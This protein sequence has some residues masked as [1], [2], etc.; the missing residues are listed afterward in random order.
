MPISADI[1]Y[2][3][4]LEN[5]DQSSRGHAATRT[6]TEARQIDRAEAIVAISGLGVPRSAVAKLTGMTRGRI[7]QILE[8]AGKAGATGDAW[9]D[10]ELRRLVAER[11]AARPVPS[12]GIGLRRESVSGPHLGSGAGLM[13]RLTGDLEDDRG[14]LIEIARNL[15]VELESGKLDQL[16]ALTEDEREV[17]EGNLLGGEGQQV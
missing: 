2:A 3:Q 15:A 9:K 10:P 7:Q 12:A 1:D 17:V 5:L 8:E 6:E 13:V 11:I 14:R 4:I 16:L